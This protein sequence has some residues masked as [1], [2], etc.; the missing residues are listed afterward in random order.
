MP[1]LQT[2]EF[3]HNR[4]L[5]DQKATAMTKQHAMADAV[6]AA[7][8]S[9]VALEVLEEGAPPKRPRLDPSQATDITDR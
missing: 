4:E 6:Q 8:A 7:A 3:K 1:T 2:H 5:F 9:N